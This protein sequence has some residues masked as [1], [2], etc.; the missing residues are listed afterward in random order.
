MAG[1]NRCLLVGYM[2]QRICKQAN[3]MHVRFKPGW[4]FILG[5]FFSG[6]PVLAQSSIQESLDA[7]NAE[8]P[9]KSKAD[10]GYL[11]RL[12]TIV[13]K[14]IYVRHD[15]LVYLLRQSF[16]WSEQAGY[17][18]GMLEALRLTGEAYYTARTYDSAI[19]YHNRALV[20]ANKLSDR[21]II[22]AILNSLGTVYTGK[23]NYPEAIAN[24]LKALKIAEQDSDKDRMAAIYN[25]LGNVYYY[26][27][28]FDE[29]LANYVKTLDLAKELKDTLSI[30]LA[31]HNLG[32]VYRQKK[33]YA[34]AMQYLYEALGLGK[35]LN[36]PELDFAAK[37][38]LA[39]IFEETDSLQPAVALFTEVIEQANL[40]QDD[41]YASQ[42]YLGKA[43]A[44]F[45]SGNTI[46][47]LPLA[48]SGL[49]RAKR[50]G[51]NK[52]VRDGYELLSGI[53][54]SLGQTA[55]AFQNFKMFKMYAD[56]LNNIETE[57]SAAAM[58]AEYAYSQKEIQFQRKNLQQRW[59]IFSALAGIV[60]LAII[61]YFINKNRRNATRTNFDLQWKN[62][63]IEK[64]KVQLED[65]INSL[66]ETQSQLIQAEKMASL[67]EITAGIAHE[68]QNP[69]NFI[70]NFSAVSSDLLDE[71]IVEIGE[72]NQ[73]E[74]KAIVEDVKGNLLKI[75]SHG[76]RADGIVKSMLFHSRTSH[77]KKE[78]VDVNE[79]CEEYLNLAYHG[80]RARDKTFH[81][82][83]HK[84][85]DPNAGTIVVIP[86]DVG[87]VLLNMLNNS[88]FAVAQRKST[89]NP[90]YQPAVSLTTA[91]LNQSVQIIVE[92]NGPGIPEEI[93]SKIFQPFFTTKPTGSGTGLG[94]SIA[95]DVI[96]KVHKGNLELETER[97]KYTRFTI[98]LPVGNIPA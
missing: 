98:T 29:A 28:K 55:Q 63:E 22:S 40:Q 71:L 26:Q 16:A 6:N 34:R 65:V 91:R 7:L 38:E 57:R 4:L 56:S 50:I 54:E 31:G 64:Q 36:Y 74:V 51:Q 95:Y 46:G 61:L 85:F 66:K 86:Q 3:M 45:R 24:Y 5:I 53:H 94:L 10:T 79:L 87:R 60:F 70:N 27:S 75:E 32:S 80:M 14:S 89:E 77:G 21:N 84:N 58:E 48:D 33:E 42:A 13:N 67:G 23:G 59:I 92:D 73:E 90:D 9:K 72:G 62:K 35:T 93:R 12:H 30:C 15:S 1:L 20:L 76:K 37:V 44:F 68:I 97:G 41:L 49:L 2:V 19:F 47:A 25:N 11:N 43:R 69:L 8:Y 39:Q 78:P 81:V 82:H 83:M 88:F 17:T 52:L 96:I 18:N